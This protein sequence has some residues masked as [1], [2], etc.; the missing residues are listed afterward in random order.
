MK[1]AYS[2][3]EIMFESFMSSTSIASCGRDTD[4]PSTKTCG[5]TFGDEDQVFFIGKETGC[6][7]AVADGFNGV[8][9]HNPSDTA[10]LFG[11]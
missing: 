8:C 7:V 3:P 9:Y 5:I 2:K 10:M 1:K 6:N 4:L 11:S